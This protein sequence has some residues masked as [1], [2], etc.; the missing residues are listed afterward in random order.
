[1]ATLQD[2]EI[3]IDGLLQHPLGAGNYQLV[4][5]VEPKAYEAYIFGLCLRAARELGANPTLRGINGSPNPFIFRGGPGQIHSDYRNYG[6]ASFSVNGQ[7]F[8]VHAGVEFRGTSR[9]THELDV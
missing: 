2:L 9:M 3:A 1:M 8:E 7:G 4:R 5:Q 6:F